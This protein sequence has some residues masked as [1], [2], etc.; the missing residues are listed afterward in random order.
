MFGPW[1]PW[2]LWSLKS[3]GYRDITRNLME[4]GPGR[5]VEQLQRDMRDLDYALEKGSAT[6]KSEIDDRS[7]GQ[8]KTLHGGI[9]GV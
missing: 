1:R 9:V 6:N 5:S 2:Q 7:Y 8:Q 4:S 3:V